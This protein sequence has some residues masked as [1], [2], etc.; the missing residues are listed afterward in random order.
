MKFFINYQANSLEYHLGYGEYW[1]DLRQTKSKK[2]NL[3][4]IKDIEGGIRHKRG[5]MRQKSV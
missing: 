4:R 1:D 3:G 2:V 5:G